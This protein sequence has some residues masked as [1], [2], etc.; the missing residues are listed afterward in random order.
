MY[1]AIHSTTLSILQYL[2]VFRIS[3]TR[4]SKLK[5]IKRNR[6][7]GIIRKSYQRRLISSKQRISRK[8]SIAKSRLPD[9]LVRSEYLRPWLR[10]NDQAVS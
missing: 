8:V 2:A 1:F 5:S 6:D 4:I 3:R 9:W 10:K 7:E